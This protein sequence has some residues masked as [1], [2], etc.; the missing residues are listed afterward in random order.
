MSI[1][2]RINSIEKKLNIKKMEIIVAFSDGKS[3]LVKR[4]SSGQINRKFKSMDEV[5]SF[6]KDRNAMLI[7]IKNFR[8]IDEEDTTSISE[9]IEAQE[10]HKDKELNYDEMLTLVKQKAEEIRNLE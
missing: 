1:R 2:S 9:N 4:D 8:D 5:K 3:V 10:L 7:N 6:Y